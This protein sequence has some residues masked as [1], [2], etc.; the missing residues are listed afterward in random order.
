MQTAVIILSCALVLS[1]VANYIQ[2]QWWLDLKEELWKSQ[3]WIDPVACV[4]DELEIP[5]IF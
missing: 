3:T 1:L 5:D 4:T 2:H